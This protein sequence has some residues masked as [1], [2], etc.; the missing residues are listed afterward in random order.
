MI[1]GGLG[2]VLIGVCGGGG[3]VN[4]D[5]CGCDDKRWVRGSVDRCVCGGGG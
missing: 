2:G 3:V 5:M 4:L 1:R